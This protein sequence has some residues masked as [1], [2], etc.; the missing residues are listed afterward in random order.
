MHPELQKI[1]AGIIRAIPTQGFNG[2][3]TARRSFDILLTQVDRFVYNIDELLWDY[4]DSLKQPK[5]AI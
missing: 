2:L 5:L 3:H 1:A 4:W